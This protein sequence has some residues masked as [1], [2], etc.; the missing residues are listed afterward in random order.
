FEFHT[1]GLPRRRDKQDVVSMRVLLEH[2]SSK[3]EPSLSLHF[4]S[5][6]S[7]WRTLCGCLKATHSHHSNTRQEH[8]NTTRAP[9]K[10]TRVGIP[11]SDSNRREKANAGP[12]R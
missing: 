12:A 3:E 8:E 5:P 9:I 4:V 10:Q 6:G 11:A 2:L 7:S 1:C